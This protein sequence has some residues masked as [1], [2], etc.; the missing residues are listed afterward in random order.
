MK[1]AITV[2]E[3]NLSVIWINSKY[4]LNPNM[5]RL[6]LQQ[7]I[8]DLQE[9]DNIL[10]AYGSCGGGLIG[11]KANTANLIIPKMDDCISILLCRPDKKNIRKAKTF[12]VTKAWIDSGEGLISEY[13]RAVERYGVVKA[14]RIFKIM[15]NSY[16]YLMLIDTSS[17]NM[18]NYIPIAKEI[19]HVTKLDFI[20]GLGYTWLLEKLLI[21][22]YDKDFCVISKGEEVRPSNF[23]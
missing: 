11:L 3:S 5:L 13:E 9:V 1:K 8:D 4:H 23:I 2:T 18:G 6:K 21:G 15:F 14:E 22:P 16:K 20:I 19:A 12:F 10:F 17:Y 7:E